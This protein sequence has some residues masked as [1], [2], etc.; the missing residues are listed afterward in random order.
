M[1]GLDVYEPSF[2]HA[3]DL[4][5]GSHLP[6]LNHQIEDL[7]KNVLKAYADFILKEEI[8][9]P[10]YRK[11]DDQFLGSTGLHRINWD[12]SKYE[13]GYWIDSGSSKKG[14]ITEVVERLTT[15]LI[16]IKQSELRTH[17]SYQQTDS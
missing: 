9:L 10:I 2:V 16:M 17:Q 8:R 15:L 6:N 12:I 4:S 3:M 1:D 7:E 5:H 13:I 14:Y 11:E